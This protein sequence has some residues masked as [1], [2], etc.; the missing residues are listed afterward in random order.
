MIRLLKF[1]AVGVAGMAVQLI[2][3][4]I[5][6]SG[7]RMNTLAATVLAVETAILHNFVWHEKF[8]WRDRPAAGRLG[9]LLRFNFTTG[10]LSILSN[11]VLMGLLVSRFKL[12]YLPANVMAIVATSLLNY[13]VADRFVFQAGD[14]PPESAA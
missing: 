2:V 12:P 6:V 7:L 9:R 14:I 13:L 11:V 4:A 5:L 3:L 1:N 10:A 8:T